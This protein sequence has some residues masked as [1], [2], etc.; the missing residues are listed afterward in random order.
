MCFL[1]KSDNGRLQ[2]DLLYEK[3]PGYG[4][5]GIF[6]HP[7]G[8]YNDDSHPRRGD[9]SRAYHPQSAV[10]AMYHPEAAAMYTVYA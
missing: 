6:L 1:C 3:Y 4:H 7:P 9:I 5:S 2:S 8:K 10:P